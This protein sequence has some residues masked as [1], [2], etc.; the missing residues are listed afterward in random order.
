LFGTTIPV[1][2]ENIEVLVDDERCKCEFTGN[3]KIEAYAHSRREGC[4]HRVDIIQR[5]TVPTADGSREIGI[6]LH[7]LKIEIQ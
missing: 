2:A 1:D 4:S 6:A 3:D 7:K 5:R